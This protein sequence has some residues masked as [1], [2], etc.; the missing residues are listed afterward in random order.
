M[1]SL[2]GYGVSSDS[3]GEE[4]GAGRAQLA[5]KNVKDETEEKLPN[6][7][8]E[9]GSASSEPSSDSEQ[10]EEQASGAP[11][12]H[13]TENVPSAP[14][15]LLPPLISTACH[16]LPPP[17]LGTLGSAAL[18]G[19]SSVFTNPF[20]QRAE[21]R[22]N[23][24]RKHVPL[25]LQAHPTQIG[26]KKMC[27]AYRKNGRCRFGSR[28]KFAHDSDLQSTTTTGRALEPAVSE[29]G[30]VD[31]PDSDCRA[32]ISERDGEDDEDN[33]RRK[34]QRVGLNDSLVP[35]KR[36]LKQY[37]MLRDRTLHS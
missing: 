25:T 7:M 32:T 16:K 2:V 33:H 27:L 13:C 3:E 18:P 5:D 35:P 30:P 36:A 31:P 29:N 11:D 8:L 34:K 12:P 23:V 22:L 21:E 10:E 20:K 9:S 6:F 28:C 19:G 4:D 1:N 37:S 24:L 14:E 15:T 17:P 26:G